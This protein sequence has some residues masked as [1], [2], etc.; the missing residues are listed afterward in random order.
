MNNICPLTT[1]N[2]GH[3]YRCIYING[4]PD[5]TCYNKEKRCGAARCT[6]PDDPFG[7]HRREPD[8]SIGF[9]NTLNQGGI[10]VTAINMGSGTVNVLQAKPKKK[11]QH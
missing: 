7:D 9:A 11:Y 2:Y 3:H 6:I 10:A 8:G 1:H 5:C 4:H